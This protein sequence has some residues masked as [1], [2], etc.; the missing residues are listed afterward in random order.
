[1]HVA[2]RGNF[3]VSFS[4]ES[5]VAA[6]LEHLGHTVV[7]LQEDKVSWAETIK[8]CERAD[9]FL[10]TSTHSY[11]LKWDGAA[12]AVETLNEMLPTAAFHLDLFF[13]LNRSGSVTRE[14]WF[15]L[16]F[17]FT[18]DGDHPEEFEAAGVNHHWSL[19]GVYHAECQLGSARDKFKSD[20][21]FVG[22]WQGHYHQ[23]WRGR[24]DLVEWLRNGYGTSVRFWPE[25]GK[26]AVRGLELCDLYA[27]VKIVVGDSCFADTAKRY[28]SDRVYETVGRGGFLLYPRIEAVEA[29]LIDKVHLCYYTP[30]DWDELRDLVKHWLHPDQ[31]AQRAAIRK[32]GSAFVREHCSYLNRLTAMLGV[33]GLE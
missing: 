10:W 18:A 20:L 21:A 30:G 11:A 4:T 23:E 2:Y 29:E 6:S 17:C 13:G 16:K 25:P 3:G 1:M 28:T 9:L 14:P 33:M 22:S 7:R 8:A 26:H 19:P 24:F 31:D 15:K 32:A 12:K 5:H 27:S